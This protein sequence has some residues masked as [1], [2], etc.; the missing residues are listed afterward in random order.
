MPSIAFRSKILYTVTVP[1]ALDD[2]STFA[3]GF[4][5]N[6]PSSAILHSST[7]YVVCGR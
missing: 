6:S 7:L 5:K 1:N 2:Y 3:S 4:P